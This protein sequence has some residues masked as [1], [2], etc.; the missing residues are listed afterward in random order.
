MKHKGPSDISKLQRVPPIPSESVQLRALAKLLKGGLTRQT[1]DY[2]ADQMEKMAERAA[3]GLHANPGSLIVY[4]NPG[5]KIKVGD[6]ITVG[7][8]PAL[9]YV[10]QIK[11]ERI[12]KPTGYFFH[13]FGSGDALFIA[14]LRDGQ[15]VILIANVNGR[16][17]WGEA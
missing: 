9:G 7:L 11:Y 13:D 16:E 14:Q 17:L 1:A 12:K 5:G 3:G 15:R 4:A 8:G 2:I 6:D 10:E